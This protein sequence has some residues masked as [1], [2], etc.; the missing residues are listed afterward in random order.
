MQ[1]TTY[2]IESALV[3]TCLPH[4]AACRFP[5]AP[6]APTH[7]AGYDEL[8]AFCETIKAC[9]EGLNFDVGSL[10]RFVLAI[11]MTGGVQ[12]LHRL[13]ELEEGECVALCR[14]ILRDFFHSSDADAEV[15]AT[16]LC[17]AA[18]DPRS[19]LFAIFVQGGD[20]FF[21]FRFT[22][23]EFDVYD[24]RAALEIFPRLATHRVPTR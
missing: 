16:A 18:N 20:A 17:N 22:P 23:Q 5:S 7:L 19:P 11:Y 15:R 14:R 6:A 9:S 2:P 12:E 10:P 21:A 1:N 13:G 8:I 3:M 4:T 24:F